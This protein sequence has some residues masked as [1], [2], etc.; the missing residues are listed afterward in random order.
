MD[1]NRIY[2]VEMPHVVL[3]FYS[4][5]A[6]IASFRRNCKWS[7][8]QKIHPYKSPVPCADCINHCPYNAWKEEP[9]TF[10]QTHFNRRFLQLT[11]NRLISLLPVWYDVDV[12]R[13]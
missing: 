6:G 8:W 7:F 10:P 11:G 4:F 13:R 1:F 9:R 12:R 3:L 2:A 5:F